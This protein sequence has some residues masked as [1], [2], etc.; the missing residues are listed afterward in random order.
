MQASISLRSPL[1]IQTSF[2]NKTRE[3][4]NEN[5]MEASSIAM[6]SAQCGDIVSNVSELSRAG[7]ATKANVNAQ[8]AP[9][10]PFSEHG[11]RSYA[12]SITNTIE[13]AS[14]TCKQITNASSLTENREQ[15]SPS[16]FRRVPASASSVAGESPVTARVSF[17]LSAQLVGAGW[18]P[19]RD[20]YLRP[21]GSMGIK[22]KADSASYTT[23]I[24]SS[25]SFGAFQA[26]ALGE[27]RAGFVRLRVIE[28]PQRTG[29]AEYDSELHSTLHVS[30]SVVLVLPFAPAA[31]V[32]AGAKLGS[33]LPLPSQLDEG[34]GGGDP[35]RAP[36][37]CRAILLPCGVPVTVAHVLPH[38]A[39]SATSS[40]Q[41][42]GPPGSA[43]SVSS[44]SSVAGSAQQLVELGLAPSRMDLANHRSFGTQL[45]LTIAEH[46][47]QAKL[48]LHGLPPLSPH[49]ARG[50][51]YARVCLPPPVVMP[52]G[53]DRPL[54]TVP[55]AALLRDVVP[56]RTATREHGGA[57]LK[58]LVADLRGMRL[59]APPLAPVA[60]AGAAESS[61]LSESDA[62]AEWEP[63]AAEFLRQRLSAALGVQIPSAAP[64]P[65]LPVAAAAVGPAFFPAPVAA[66]GQAMAAVAKGKGR[67]RAGAA[68]SGAKGKS[69]AAPSPPAVSTPTAPV[70]S[71]AAVAAPASV[72]AKPVDVSEVT[73]PLFTHVGPLVILS[74]GST[75]A[76]TDAEDPELECTVP[77]DAPVPDASAVVDDTLSSGA[78]L[79]GAG[80]QPA[81]IVAAS[82]PSAPAVPASGS[83]GA[84]AS[85][86]TMFVS[87]KT[88][89]GVRQS[90]GTGISQATGLR[91]PEP[92]DDARTTGAAALVPAK[93]LLGLAKPALGGLS[94]PRAAGLLAASLG[95]GGGKKLGGGLV[96]RKPVFTTETAAGGASA[97][98]STAAAAAPA[99]ATAQTHRPS[100]AIAPT[101]FVT[102]RAL[103]PTAKVV[104]SAPHA[105]A[106]PA[107]RVPAVHATPQQ[108][109]RKPV[110]YL[111]DSESDDSNSDDEDSEEEGGVAAPAPRGPASG[112]RPPQP[113]ATK[114][115]PVTPAVKTAVMH[116]AS[117]SART[118]V[119]M[120]AAPIGSSAASAGSAGAGTASE[121]DELV[122]LVRSV[123]AASGASGGNPLLAWLAAPSSS[124]A[125]SSLE[126][127][128]FAKPVTD[129]SWTRL[130]LSLGWVRG[131]SDLL[132]LVM[133][134]LDLSSL[135]ASMTA[136]AGL[137]SLAALSKGAGSYAPPTRG[138]P[139]LVIRDST[140]EDRAREE[141]EGPGRAG[142]ADA[143]LLD[144]DPSVA[145]DAAAEAK[146]AE[147]AREEEAKKERM[148][149]R[150]EK[151]AAK[152]AA[153]GKGASAAGKAAAAGKG[154][155]ADDND[156]DGEGG[157][158]GDG[159]AAGGSKGASVAGVKRKA[160]SDSLGG[161]AA[162][163]VPGTPAAK[164]PKT[165]GSAAA[166]GESVED[167][168]A[169]AAV[170]RR[171]GANPDALKRAC[172]IKHLK[173][174][175][176]S[177]KQPV[178]GTKGALIDRVLAWM[179]AH[180][181]AA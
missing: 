136:G 77:T 121:A 148:A 162:G 107:P 60:A 16:H 170:V 114:A 145:N 75:A 105:Q 9:I 97:H 140:E 45:P 3:I 58:A 172:E 4:F 174:F 104:P 10:S 99:P 37:L 30:A 42:P 86:N 22:A 21:L 108:Q 152:A 120:P 43:A 149:A 166:G 46:A 177:V 106:A 180:P 59:L 6:Y 129:D 122:R 76:V 73:V 95:S 112:A 102:A 29:P 26:S 71:S 92:L 41:P 138:P 142:G 82:R 125:A 157:A 156:S 14:I 130:L 96:P 118:V 153:S 15:T 88:Y 161:A 123:A 44:S 87:G 70:A 155:G 98:A 53:A 116:A 94:A 181:G 168:V 119:V 25:Q 47:R 11:G 171:C 57:V 80:P 2:L 117:T 79:A 115:P 13:T 85:F 62:A 131:R 133:T 61:S 32:T 83:D 5:S 101:A 167:E 169:L 23:G 54:D 48:L 176:R 51:A 139:P 178:G 24:A 69:A 66:A 132:P 154:V 128:A 113:S 12:P 38:A 137:S 68:S 17:S 175:C 49:L 34:D 74:G 63:K 173:A 165:A 1:G 147:R 93:P 35:L 103:M 90:A 20:G 124:A 126:H 72:T 163:G 89:A 100:A 134:P 78:S 27:F 160:P 33:P 179:A 159:T 39:I 64:T 56:L 109:Q 150:K 36:E 55:L 8:N 127:P 67:A 135:P 143:G 19:F 91:E 164:K 158:G 151:A 40:P 110:A 31:L 18:I 81:P 111:S 50:Y 52:G 65:A 146:W 144:A 84:L 28:G 141:A 7:L